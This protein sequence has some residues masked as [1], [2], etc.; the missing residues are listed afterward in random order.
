MPCKP[1]SRPA[2]S[3]CH[4]YSRYEYVRANILA[5]TYPIGGANKKG[6]AQQKICNASPI[7]RDNAYL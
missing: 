6:D 2:N 1:N 4:A 5:L 7:R 3:I